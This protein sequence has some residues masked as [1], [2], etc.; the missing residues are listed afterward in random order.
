MIAQ[1]DIDVFFFYDIACMLHAHLKVRKWL[2]LLFYLV[3]YGKDSV[4]GQILDFT[5]GIPMKYPAG[6]IEVHILVIKKW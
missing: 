1:K 5:V 3:I 2:Y 4:K 6:I